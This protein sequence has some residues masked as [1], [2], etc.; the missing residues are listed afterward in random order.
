MA[1]PFTTRMFHAEQALARA[2]QYGTNGGFCFP[3]SE[4]DQTLIQSVK[5]AKDH[6]D[7]LMM[8]QQIEQLKAKIAAM[9]VAE[10]AKAEKATSA[11]QEVAER[12]AHFAMEA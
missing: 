7:K 2:I 5:D 1:D 4:T 9:E 3:V 12:V 11:L 8:K 10:A 6:L